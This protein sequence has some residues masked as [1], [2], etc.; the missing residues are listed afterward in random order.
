MRNK[1]VY[2]IAALVLLAASFTMSAFGQSNARPIPPGGILTGGPAP[3]PFP[4]PVNTTVAPH[5][6]NLDYTNGNNI[7]ADTNNV[8]HVVYTASGTIRH[9][10]SSDGGATWS[11]PQNLGA[12]TTPVIAADDTGNVGLAYILNNQVVYQYRTP[13]GN[14]SGAF[15]MTTSNGGKEPSMIGYGGK[16][17]LV[18]AGYEV[19]FHSFFTTS[20]TV[21]SSAES[22]TLHVVCA[23]VNYRLPSIAVSDPASGT[24]PVVRVAFYSDNS[25][26]TSQSAGVQVYQ[27]PAGGNPFWP[28]VA[29][30]ILN[31][32]GPAFQPAVSSLSMAADRGTGKYYLLYS[33]KPDSRNLWKTRFLCNQ[34]PVSAWTGV[35]YFGGDTTHPVIADVTAINGAD[36]F[37]TA[38]SNIEG[39]TSF[40]T[41]TWTGS[42]P[43]YNASTIKSYYGR[44][45]HVIDFMLF[46]NMT[47][48]T[49]GVNLV[50]E[51]DNSFAQEIRT[52]FW[53]A[54]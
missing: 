4:E 29:I 35:D 9:T 21:A 5:A 27:R 15:Q 52:D 41:G 53:S 33:H 28:S 51:F 23:T 31:E 2:L 54:F 17:Y 34:V 26:C 24:D 46:N 45:P 42:L 38:Y 6:G 16:M 36:R 40:K 22:V 3:T 25:Q 18:W 48:E 19:Y 14:W 30:P 44:S 43:V 8:L 37:K 20:P 12:G 32:S 1:R 13:F 10:T 7:I 49:R 39:W 47:G 11:T 50:F